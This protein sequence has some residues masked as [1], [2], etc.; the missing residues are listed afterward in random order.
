LVKFQIVK[1]ENRLNLATYYSAF[2]HLL[3]GKTYK[4]SKLLLVGMYHDV[5]I[6]IVKAVNNGLSFCFIVSIAHFIL[7]FF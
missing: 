2:V 7:I 5:A 3:K 1:L 6:S 4:S